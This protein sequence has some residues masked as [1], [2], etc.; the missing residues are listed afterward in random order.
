[1][2]S[3]SSTGLKLVKSWVLNACQPNKK[4]Y[5]SIDTG[6]WLG[7]GVYGKPTPRQI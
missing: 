3:I 4:N 2:P 1:M 5:S 7:V 6:S